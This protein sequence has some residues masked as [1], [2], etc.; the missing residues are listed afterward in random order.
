MKLIQMW[1]SVINEYINLF[2]VKNEKKLLKQL[3]DVIMIL[4]TQSCLILCDPMDCSMPGPLFITNSQN[5]LKFMSIKSVMLSNRLILCCALLLLPW[6]YP[7]IR[8]SSNEP[9]L[10]IRW[11]KYWHFSFRLSPSNEYSG[12]VFFRMNWFDLLAIHGTL[13]SLL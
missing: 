6:I 7:S 8:V 12:L 5:L 2:L 9:V 10:H 4:V 1:N 3:D 13:K 11:A